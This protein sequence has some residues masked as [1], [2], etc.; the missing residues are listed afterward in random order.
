[1]NINEKIKLLSL[2]ESGF[3]YHDV[4]DH[5]SDSE[6]CDKHD[7][8]FNLEEDHERAKGIVYEERYHNYMKIVLEEPKNAKEFS[9]PKI[10]IVDSVSLI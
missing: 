4:L 8:D 2:Q 6:W 3:F 7:I 10:E 9:L 1:M 5:L